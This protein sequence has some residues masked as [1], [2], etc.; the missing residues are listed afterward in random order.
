MQCESPTYSTHGCTHP[1]P[2]QNLT[3]LRVQLKPDAAEST[4]QSPQKMVKK[5]CA[6][7]KVARARA[8]EFVRS[9]TH[10]GGLTEDNFPVP[11]LRSLAPNLERETLKGVS[12]AAVIVF[13]FCIDL[14]ISGVIIRCCRVAGS[15]HH[16]SLSASNA[17]PPSCMPPHRCT[18]ILYLAFPCGPFY[19]D[20]IHILDILN[21]Q[22]DGASPRDM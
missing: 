16:T 15:P 19:A 11:C 22:S 21:V 12:L 4:S 6:R 14:P 20:K 18:I 9:Y 2:T 3:N 7:T 13:I 1:R 17:L 5:P 10:A 8:A